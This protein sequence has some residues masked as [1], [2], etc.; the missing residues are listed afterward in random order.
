M[1]TKREQ[2]LVQQDQ[3]KQV[4]KIDEPKNPLG[5]SL[6]W[7]AVGILTL[8]GLVVF[9]IKAGQPAPFDVTKVC[10]TAEAYH[11]HPHLSIL[12]NGQNQTIPQGIG[13]VSPTCIRP[14][15]THSDDGIIHVEFEHQRDFTLA[16]FF[17]VW[18]QPYGADQVLGFKKDEKHDLTLTVD[19]LPTTNWDNVILKDQEKIVIN[20]TDKK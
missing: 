3:V 11:I 20:Y 14:L 16:E 13:I 17:R 6:L 7:L 1:V 12:V 2:R 8:A 9:F 15:H 10:L 5:R 18:G 4:Y 19:G